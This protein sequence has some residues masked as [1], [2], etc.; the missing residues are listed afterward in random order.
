MKELFCQSCG[1]P[2]SVPEHF[3]ISP[4]AYRK[5]PTPWKDIPQINNTQ[6]KLSPE[7]REISSTNSIYIRI[8]DAYSSPKSYNI[9]W[10]KL[11]HFAVD[12]QL[13]CL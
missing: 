10:G 2:L 11:Y 1:M 4:S 13:E 12:N 8:I 6:C 3:G 9:A 5:S 7:I